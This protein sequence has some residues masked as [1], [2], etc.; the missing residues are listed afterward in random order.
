MITVI[1]GTRTVTDP[2][3]LRSAVEACGWVPTCVI[4]GGARGADR[5]GELWASY[6]NVPCRVFPAQW[7]DYGKAAGYLRNEKMS[8]EAEAGIALWDGYSKGTKHMIQLMQEQGKRLCV[9]R[10][11]L[12]ITEEIEH[13]LQLEDV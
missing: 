9:L 6:H 7:D 12:N 1:F 5:L 2:E 10:T 3:F 8:L 4:S 11:D 13:Q